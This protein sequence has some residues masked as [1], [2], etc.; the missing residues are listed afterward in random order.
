M[1]YIP[2]TLASFAAPNTPLMPD[3][4][5]RWLPPPARVFRVSAIMISKARHAADAQGSAHHFPKVA[6]SRA[7]GGG[8]RHFNS[9][10][11]WWSDEVAAT[12]ATPPTDLK[13]CTPVLGTSEADKASAGCVQARRLGGYFAA[14]RMCLSQFSLNGAQ[15]ASLE[16]T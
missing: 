7:L 4:T 8:R 12:R 6:P 11:G 13:R 9:M 16:T 14:S 2:E 10:S 15:M 3:W 1:D 5:R